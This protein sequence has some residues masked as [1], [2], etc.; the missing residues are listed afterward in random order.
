MSW[1]PAQPLE[2][3]TSHL[4][5]QDYLSSMQGY[6]G[7]ASMTSANPRLHREMFSLAGWPLFAFSASGPGA[8]VCP[9]ERCAE[10]CSLRALAG[11][12]GAGPGSRV[13]ARGLRSPGSKHRCP[14]WE[15][16]PMLL[17]RGGC[18]SWLQGM[19]PGMPELPSLPGVGW[20]PAVGAEGP[21]GVKGVLRSTWSGCCVNAWHS[22]HIRGHTA[23][24]SGLQI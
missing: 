22:L 3:E 19:L 17:R 4:I 21:G 14:S 24:S 11:Y 12:T 1:S 9:G 15:A 13:P 5:G 7:L 18:W 20:G 16:P 6:R 2:G 10:R 8:A 23:S